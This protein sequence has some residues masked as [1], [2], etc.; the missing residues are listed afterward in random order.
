MKTKID[1]TKIWWLIIILLPM[2]SVGAG[3]L[4]ETFSVQGYMEAWH[5]SERV[6]DRTVA[7]G[8][9]DYAAELCS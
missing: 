4:S 5:D 3:I 6:T 1:P 9:Y 8:R 2:I 7:Q